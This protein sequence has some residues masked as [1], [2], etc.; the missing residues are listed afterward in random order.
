MS[1]CGMRIGDV[2]TY[3][4]RSVML[5]G[6][7]PMSVPDRRAHVRDLVTGDELE[8]PVDELEEDEGLPPTG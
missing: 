6:L 3:R 1:N 7:E 2:L 5:L 8:V 4:G